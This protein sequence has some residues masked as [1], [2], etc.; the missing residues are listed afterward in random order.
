MQQLMF[1]RWR[2]EEV[3]EDDG[4]D[5][6]EDVDEDVMRWDWRDDEVLK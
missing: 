1:R 5:D 2:I 3:D 4:G 6:D